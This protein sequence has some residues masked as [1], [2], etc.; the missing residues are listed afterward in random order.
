[1]K[2]DTENRPS[3]SSSGIS[4]ANTISAITP[5]IIDLIS[6]GLTG[7]PFNN[8]INS[9]PSNLATVARFLTVLRSLFATCRNT[10][11]PTW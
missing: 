9:W 11:S 6:S 4:M 5:L 8:T 3:D 1:M 2:Q 7:K 10:L